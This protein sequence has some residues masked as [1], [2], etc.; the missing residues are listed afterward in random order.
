MGN[1]IKEFFLGFDAFTYPACLRLKGDSNVSSLCGGITC[2]LIF[3]F[4]IYLFIVDMIELVEHE[5]V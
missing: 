2:L 4:F 1:K 3:S 5:K